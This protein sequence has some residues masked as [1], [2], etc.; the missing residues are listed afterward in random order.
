MTNQASELVREL[1]SYSG[2]SRGRVLTIG[3][4]E[5][6]ASAP[7]RA[8]FEIFSVDL[9]NLA[10]VDLAEFDLCLYWA[11]RGNANDLQHTLRAVRRA[12]PV[13]GALMLIV[14]ATAP[15]TDAIQ[16][17]LIQADFTDL[18]VASHGAT[19]RTFLVRPKQKR[20]APLLSV[21]VPVYNERTTFPVMMGHL[22]EKTIEGL[23]IEVVVI[24][25]NST[26]GTRTEVL[27]YA[28]HPG[29]HTLFQDK[30]YGKGHALRAG[31]EIANGDLIL[32]QDADLEYDID[33]Y[34]ALI[35]PLMRFETQFV[36]GAR[37]NAGDCP[38]NIRRFQNSKSVATYLNIGH[39]LFLAL[40]NFVYKQS[41]TDPFTMFKVFRRECIYGLRLESNR[42]DIDNELVIKLLR[43]GYKP[44]EVPVNYVA[45]SYQEGKK[46][47]PF[48]DA[49]R[50]LRALIKFK[51]APLYADCNGS[52]AK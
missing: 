48:G 37:R 6:F 31:L 13:N 34:D 3:G 14:S 17:L 51:N 20:A 40:F 16:G 22:L 28:G 9:D 2:L 26:D 52:G 24:E 33:D 39:A 8:D 25:S 42:F 43:K 11:S 19:I 10:T 47:T 7:L 23:D 21:L 1:I 36:L 38:W 12:L 4:E 41:L 29:V 46:I 50:W 35:E 32:F 44:M 45:R 30:P 5:D 18:I 49:L 15:S 27:K